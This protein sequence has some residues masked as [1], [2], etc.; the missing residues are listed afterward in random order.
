MNYWD[1]QGYVMDYMQNVGMPME[2]Y[3]M[4]VMPEYQL[5]AMYPKTYKI[6]QPVVESTC[7]KML[8]SHGPMFIP[9]QDQL[10]AMIDDVYKRVEADVDIAIKQSPRGRERQFFG[11]GRRILRD[12]IGALLITSLIRRRRRPFF[13]F[14]GFGGFGGFG[15]FSGF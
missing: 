10:E 11:G 1:N 12:F 3:P 4:V 7:D 9:T 15:G 6:I 8:G 13:G 5:E 14:P 2:N